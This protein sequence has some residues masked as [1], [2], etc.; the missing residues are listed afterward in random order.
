MSQS[1]YIDEFIQNTPFNFCAHKG[2]RFESVF[3]LLR[4]IP[5]HVYDNSG[6]F[7]KLFG[8]S[9][10]EIY[11]SSGE[12][13]TYLCFNKNLKI[14]QRR[15]TQRKTSTSDFFLMSNEKRIA[16]DSC[17]QELLTKINKRVHKFVD[18]MDHTFTRFEKSLP[19]DRW[20]IEQHLPIYA[21]LVCL[22]NAPDK[23]PLFE[24]LWQMGDSVFN[25]AIL[26]ECR[27]MPNSE[28]KTFLI[29]QLNSFQLHEKLDSKL[30]D[31]DKTQTKLK[32]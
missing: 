14:G 12:I 24:D 21:K 27:L 11:Y 32:L 1:K 25:K 17:P 20:H 16:W 18:I 29:Q 28:R 15:Q 31:K 9:F 22:T 13:D 6:M 8:I 19:L 4:E 5:F 7:Y 10:E 3:N 23:F 30:K 2:I 26:K